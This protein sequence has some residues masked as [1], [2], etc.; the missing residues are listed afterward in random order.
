MML[1]SKSSSSSSSPSVVE[2]TEDGEP[3]HHEPL[4][5]QLGARGTELVDFAAAV[6]SALDNPIQH[7]SDRGEFISW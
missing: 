2:K 7:P 6:F 5:P 3:P 4:F 1:L